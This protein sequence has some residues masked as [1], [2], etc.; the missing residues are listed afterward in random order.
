MKRVITIL[1]YASALGTV[2]A[3]FTGSYETAP[4][5]YLACGLIW[6]ASASWVLFRS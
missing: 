5:V 4:M 3:L 6:T 1:S 2:S